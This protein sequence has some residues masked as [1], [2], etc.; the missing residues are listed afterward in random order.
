MRPP[1]TAL[2]SSLSTTSSTAKLFSRYATSIETCLSRKFA[3]ES[4]GSDADELK[5]LANDLWTLHD[6]FG[7]DGGG[8]ATLGNDGDS[9]GEDEY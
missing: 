9:F 8:G 5:E 1:V 3:L 4:I 7:D 6:N 2:F